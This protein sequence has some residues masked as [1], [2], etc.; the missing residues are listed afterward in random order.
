MIFSSHVPMSYWPPLSKHM[1]Y[2][3]MICFA[4]IPARACSGVQCCKAAAALNAPSRS[5]SSPVYSF[6]FCCRILAH[7][8]TCSSNTLLT[9]F[10]VIKPH[11]FHKKWH[12]K[13]EG[14]QVL[15]FQSYIEFVLN[16]PNWYIPVLFIHRQ[17]II[18]HTDHTS[19]SYL[20]FQRLHASEMFLAGYRFQNIKIFNSRF[21][22]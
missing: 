22:R 2:R 18:C 21:S 15:V 6:V 5:V 8:A 14:S 3:E 13:N 19:G 20:D 11:P 7:N 9:S 16:Q 12:R 1:S 10:C 17:Q 4:S